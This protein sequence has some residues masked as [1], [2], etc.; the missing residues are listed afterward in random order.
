MNIIVGFEQAN[1]YIMMDGQGRTLGFIAE[2]DHGF[3]SA[4]ARQFAKTHRSFTAH[5]FDA[6]H[7]EV[8]R[9]H[10]P[11]AYINSRIRIYDPVPEGGYPDVPQSSEVQLSTATAPGEPGPTAQVSPLS[12]EEMRII[13]ETQQQWAPL[14]RKYNLFSYRPGTAT[15]TDA[16]STPRITSGDAPNTSTTALTTESTLPAAAIAAGMAQFASVNEPMLSWDFT[17]RDESNATMGSVNRNFGG[18]AREIFTDT[19]VYALRMDSA[20]AAAADSPAQSSSEQ[21]GMTLD[22]RAVMLATAVSIDFDYFSRHSSHAGGGIMPMPIFWPMG[23][24]GAAAEGGAVG[25]AGAAG[26]AEAGVVGAGA[27][28]GAEAMRGY[29]GSPG[30]AVDDAS[31]TSQ[32]P[33]AGQGGQEMSSGGSGGDAAGGQGGDVWG[34][35]YDPWSQ[36][37]PGEGQSPPSAGGDGE[38]GGSWLDTLSDWFS[39]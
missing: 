35:S 34:E 36:Q 19:G 38:G 8:L 30:G 13:G 12:L 32:E 11:F 23:T 7:R 28:A 33:F 2:R 1:R 39:D 15:P 20:A 9:I 27:I 37:S 3:G 5:V 31:P 4:M 10:R 22:R 26:A 6:Q 25:A 29:G 14:R 18:F 21:A 17:L 24:G 16:A